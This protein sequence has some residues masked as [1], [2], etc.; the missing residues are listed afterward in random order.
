MDFV[1]VHGAFHGGWCWAAVAERLRAAG[2]RVHAPSLTGLADRS[3]LFSRQVGLGTHVE[4]IAALIEHERL[5]DCVL[6]GHSYGGNV[7]TGVADRLREAVREYIYL[8]AVVPPDDATRWRWADF[9]SPADREA[10]LSAI[11]EQGRGLFLAPPSAAS[12]GIAD[13]GLAADVDRRLTP[14]PAGTYL[15]AIE[16]NSG[17]SRGL[18]RRYIA[19]S[20]P[21]YGPMRPVVARVRAEG[22]RIA[23][24]ATGHDAMLTAPDRLAQMLLES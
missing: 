17:G 11:R 23:E 1:L 18:R 21:A 7:I 12:F 3:H 16:L 19:A 8:D 10:R 20:A 6:V 5:R 2:H 22:W 24:I 14:M 4:D 9:N 15:D 13:P